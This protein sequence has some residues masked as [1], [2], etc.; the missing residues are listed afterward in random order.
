MSDESNTTGG[1]SLTP[2][3]WGRVTE[4]ILTLSAE[5]GKNSD[6][7]TARGETNTASTSSEE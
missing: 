7:A 4:S 2:T 5:V 1:N 6:A 3:E